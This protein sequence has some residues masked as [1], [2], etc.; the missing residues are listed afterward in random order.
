MCDGCNYVQGLY[1]F[2][3][4]WSSFRL[5]MIFFQNM[6]SARTWEA[7][8]SYLWHVLAGRKHGVYVCRLRV[9]VCSTVSMRRTAIVLNGHTTSRNTVCKERNVYCIINWTCR[10]DKRTGRSICTVPAQRVIGWFRVQRKNNR[11]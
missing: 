3:E 10:M 11:L 5:K 8:Q 2:W 1:L 9:H 7:F 4:L 6:A